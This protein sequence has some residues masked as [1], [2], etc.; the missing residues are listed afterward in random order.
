MKSLISEGEIGYI[1]GLIDDEGYIRL[2][3]HS[4][5][6]K[7]YADVVIA[8]T[9]DKMLVEV[10]DMLG[11]GKLRTQEIAQLSKYGHR[12]DMWWLS[13]YSK[14]DVQKLLSMV[15]PYLILKEREAELVLEW[16][17]VRKTLG[18]YS[19]RKHPLEDVIYKEFMEVKE[20]RLTNKK[21]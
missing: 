1:A 3:R 18:Y 17:K 15:I 14:G 4:Q 21:Y 10:R 16:V 9:D 19:V 8:N 2:R 13:F 6:D 11:F 12:K 20:K 7:Y 5:R